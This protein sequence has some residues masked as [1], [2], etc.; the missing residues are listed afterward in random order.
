M[1]KILIVDDEPTT[2]QRLSEFF[3]GK[4]YQVITATGGKE[5][6]SKVKSEQPVLMLLDVLLPGMNGMEVLAK[7]K[8]KN[9]ELKV[10]MITG[11][12]D[13]E[14]AQKAIGL[15]AD[16]YITKPVDLESLEKSI[17]LKPSVR[18]QI[19]RHRAIRPLV[20]LGNF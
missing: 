4:G 7:V 3:D 5:A 12:R 13:E 10:I 1:A 11:V 8:A 6:L 15:G 2:I 17:W 20:S 9:P 18:W 14:V 19:K 16:D